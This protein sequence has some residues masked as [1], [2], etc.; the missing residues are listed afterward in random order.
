VNVNFTQMISFTCTD[1]ER[2][3]EMAAGW[4]RMQAEADLMGYM[5]S[6][7]LADREKPGHYVLVAEFGVIDPDVS[8]ADEAMR[9]N[10][11]PETNEWVENLL[12]IVDGELTYGNYDEVYRTG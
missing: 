12:E 4:D 1:P 3:V 6:H 9:N 5:G 8:A 10:D 11:R 2:L 7:V